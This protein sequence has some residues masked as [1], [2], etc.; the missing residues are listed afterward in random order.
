MLAVL[1]QSGRENKFEEIKNYLFEEKFK[2]CL[3][4][5]ILENLKSEIKHKLNTIDIN[6]KTS[7][8]I[9]EKINSIEEFINFD[10]LHKNIS[11]K[12]NSVYKEKNYNELLKVFNKK[13]IY[14]DNEFLN[15]VGRTK[16]SYVE[17]VLKLLK[18]NKELR[19]EILDYI[20]L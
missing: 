1:K 16:E 14:K 18:E 19:K 13:E 2:N 8:E 20:N 11:N 12:F 9:K 4:K 7:D 17:E 5:Q 15:K 10:D 3:E 6:L